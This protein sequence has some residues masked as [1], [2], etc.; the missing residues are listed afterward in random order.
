MR[1]TKPT[2]DIRI[3]IPKVVIME[4]L[5]GESKGTTGRFRESASTKDLLDSR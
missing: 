1:G 4:G 3:A 5:D 2:E